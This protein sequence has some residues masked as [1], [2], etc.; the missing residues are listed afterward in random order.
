MHTKLALRTRTQVHDLAQP[1][2]FSKNVNTRRDSWTEISNRCVSPTNEDTEKE[3]TG[4]NVIEEEAAVYSSVIRLLGGGYMRSLMKD[5][6]VKWNR[7]AQYENDD[8]SAFVLTPPPKQTRRS[9][10]TVEKEED[11]WGD[12]SAAVEVSKKREEE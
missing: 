7:S 1:L 4:K 3:E 5:I 8:E 9:S 6:R 10:R 11:E 2:T 12:F